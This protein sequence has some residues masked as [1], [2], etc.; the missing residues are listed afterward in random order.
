MPR[1]FHR[2]PASRAAFMLA[3][4]VVTACSAAG[5]SPAETATAGSSPKAATSTA[6]VTSSGPTSG[7]TTVT[8]SVASSSA[9][10]SPVPSA[11]ITSST[12][13][14]SSP[15]QPAGVRL[16][17]NGGVVSP[18][19]SRMP[20]DATA[21]RAWL[22][23]RLGVRGARLE[24]LC[25]MSAQTGYSLHYGKLRILVIGATVKGWEYPTM[26]LSTPAVAATK[27]LATDRG[28]RLGATLSQ[29]QRA[30]PGHRLADWAG[31]FRL[32]RSGEVTF[33]FATQRPGETMSK[34]TSGYACGE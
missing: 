32:T 13:T 9:P 34:M 4:L 21:A 15:V 10:A 8:P 17:G 2:T 29:V 16:I 11:P 5:I 18:D 33:Y 6:P 31:E 25:E 19:G 24:E 23:A 22:D 3:V 27:A 26:Y 14:P 12:P 7:P 28:I 1:P 30:Y 20:S